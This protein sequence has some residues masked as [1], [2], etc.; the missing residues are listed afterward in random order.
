MDYSTLIPADQKLIKTVSGDL[1]GDGKQDL[2]L[3]SDEKNPAITDTEGKAKRTLWIFIADDS[4]NGFTLASS[5]N[6]IIPCEECGGLLGDPFQ[7]LKITKPGE[8]KLH[9]AGGSRE[10]WALEYFFSFD[11][12]AK[13][14]FLNQL[15]VDAYDTI[16]EKSIQKYYS[17]KDFKNP[18]FQFVDHEETL[19]FTAS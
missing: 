10:R 3:V 17:T 12:N 6:K 7:E 13:K 18:D 15:T 2:L 16:A 11:S 4:A 9:I 5:N 19:E 1:N 8:F 14:W